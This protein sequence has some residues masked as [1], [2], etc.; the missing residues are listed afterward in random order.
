MYIQCLFE[1]QFITVCNMFILIKC[2]VYVEINQYQFDHLVLQSLLIGLLIK[3]RISKWNSY[4]HIKEL[5]PILSEWWFSDQSCKS[6]KSDGSR[7]SKVVNAK[8]NYRNETRTRSKRRMKPT[9]SGTDDQGYRHVSQT[10]TSSEAKLNVCPIMTP[11]RHITY[12]TAQLHESG[13][14]VFLTGQKC[15]YLHANS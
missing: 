10:S 5:S 11:K 8:R 1:C 13:L 9:V 2:I 6:P 4:L 14:D 7:S 3:H 15:P 12:T